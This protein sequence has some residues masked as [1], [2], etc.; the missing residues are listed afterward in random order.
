MMAGWRIGGRGDGNDA[1]TAEGEL[2]GG[3]ARQLTDWQGV[4][5]IDADTAA[6]IAAFEAARH[7]PRLPAALAILG[8]FTMALGIIAIIAAN[9]DAIP[10]GLR[11]GLHVAL[12]L[13]LGAAAWLWRGQGAAKG[14]P[15]FRLE[16]A[17]LLLSLSTLALIAHI[18]QS[19]HLQGDLAG[20]LRGW[21]LLVTPFTLMAVRAPLH[22]S[23]WL[24]GL[25]AWLSAELSDYWLT[26]HEWRLSGTAVMLAFALLYAARAL[27]PPLDPAWA[28]HIGRAAV[29]TL[30]AATSFVLLVLRLLLD[31]VPPPAVVNDATI[32]AIVGFVAIGGA[33]L[34]CPVDRAGTRR[35]FGLALALSPGLAV[36]P[37]I[38]SQS[39][40][41]IVTGV[42]FCLYWVALGK[43]ALDAQ[44]P[45][46]FKLAVALIALRVFVFYLEATGG[47]L[48]TGFGLLAGGA[49]LLALALGARRIMAWG[50]DKVTED[51]P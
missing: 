24:S 23:L 31:A 37:F 25:V 35:L 45:G 32:A 9:W 21:L 14:M 1:A 18:G 10:I 28:R 39:P 40:S 2:P 50:T 34:L 26:L 7:R 4:G 33:H 5:L 43:L 49:V 16:G 27:S 17:L 8:F 13:G 44:R 48:A 36:L 30:V 38:L 3:L 11:L 41:A 51:A 15:R 22:R 29:A 19:F 46:F 42:L 20:L 47:L 6:R 12:N